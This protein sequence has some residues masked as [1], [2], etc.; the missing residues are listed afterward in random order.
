[1]IPSIR[2]LS[3]LRAITKS[4]DKKT[5]NF[6]INH[7]SSLTED[8]GQRKRYLKSKYDKGLDLPNIPKHTR[9]NWVRSKEVF[10]EFLEKLDYNN[11]FM[12]SYDLTLI[13]RQNQKHE[14]DVA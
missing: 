6:K 4:R 12:S 10:S 14:Q 9:R 13:E 1:M 11:D 8:S 5:E 7:L 3:E 2:A